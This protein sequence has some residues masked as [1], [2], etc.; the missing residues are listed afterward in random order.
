MIQWISDKIT[1]EKKFTT[2][3]MA[4]QDSL[5]QAVLPVHL[6]WYS[7]P[8][9]WVSVTDPNSAIFPWL[10]KPSQ[11]R[12][13]LSN[14]SKVFSLRHW[15]QTQTTSKICIIC[16]PNIAKLQQPNDEKDIPRALHLAGWQV[17][18]WIRRNSWL[19]PIHK[20]EGQNN[21]SLCFI[22]HSIHSALYPHNI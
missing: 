2:K 1:R 19:D 17:G 11:T 13:R 8:Q 22:S 9:I 16:L 12:S 15:N 20:K 6:R 4:K 21:S 18:R 14:L 5:P 10:S 7:H 3:G